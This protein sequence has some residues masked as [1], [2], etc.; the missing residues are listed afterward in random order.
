MTAGSVSELV[1][2]VQRLAEAAVV[3]LRGSADMGHADALRDRLDGLA[4]EPA[5]TIVLDLAELEYISSAGLGA[6]L[7]AH[8]KLRRHG[9][10]LHLVNPRPFILRLL[11]TTR[12]TELFVVFGS[13]EEALRC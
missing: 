5:A 3:R 1:V 6:L 4:Q 13:L 11:E 2:E 7:S 8:A 10:R 12:L 9:G